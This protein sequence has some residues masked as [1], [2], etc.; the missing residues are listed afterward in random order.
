MLS[1]INLSFIKADWCSKMMR[2]N[3]FFKQLAKTLEKFYTAC[4]NGLWDSIGEHAWGN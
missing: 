2:G 1:E 3:V 4:C